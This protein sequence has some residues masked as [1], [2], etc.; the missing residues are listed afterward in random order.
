[1]RIPRPTGPRSS[2]AL[3]FIIPLAALFSHPL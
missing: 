1:M 3:A 2:G